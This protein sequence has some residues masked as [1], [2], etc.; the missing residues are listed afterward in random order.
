MA[1][2]AWDR[3]PDASPSA[4]P[5]DAFPDA[6]ASPRPSSLPGDVAKSAAAGV[7]DGVLSFGGSIG[8]VNTLAGRGLAWGLEKLAGADPSPQQREAIDAVRGGPLALLHPK[9]T[10]DLKRP[11]EA[12]TGPFHKP[13]TT[14]GEYARTIGEFA[15]SA[16]LGS[17]RLGARIVGDVLIPAVAS[18]TAGQV[19]EGTAAEPFA[20]AAGALGGNLAVAGARAV[21]GAPTSV[22]ARAARAVDPGQF[23]EAQRLAETARRV[24]VP[25][26][27]PEAIGEATRGGSKLA[28]VQRTV[29]GSLAGGTTTSRFFSQ[30][31]QQVDAA[32]RQV[33]DAI[34]PAP[35]AP[36]TL[37]PRAAQAAEVALDDVRRGINTATRPAYAAAEAHALDP[38]DFEPIARDPAFAASLRRLRADEVLGPQF[39]GQPDNSIAVID[40]V[41]KDMRDRGVALANSA[42]PG[43][44]GL[45]SAAYSSGAT[46]AR[47][48]ARAPA[49]GGVQA[50][51][52]ALTMQS[53]ARRQN[54]EPLEQG[55]LGRIA[56]AADTPAAYGEILPTKPLAG[57]V[58]EI[59][60]A[61]R[62][63]RGQ[64]AEL[65]PS[66]VR[67]SLADGFDQASR[68]I[69]TGD[70]QSVGGRFA[71]A[72][73][74]TP[75]QRATLDAVLEALGLPEA[76]QQTNDL[77]DVLRAT[78]QRRP[79]GSPTDANRQINERLDQVAMPVAIAASP[80]SA[81]S[82]V[83]SEIR[84]RVRQAAQDRAHSELAELFTAPDSVQLI[85]ELAARRDASPLAAMFA[86][87][88]LQTQAGRE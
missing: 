62:R 39:E 20:R 55:P 67:Q 11:V 7:A 88:A 43:F 74:G 26:S 50:Y 68:R 78:S 77:L 15:P 69:A 18:E 48:I 66:L 13:E 14:A 52:D 17:G 58:D 33:L 85:R 10:A 70:N 79:M 22:A 9:T 53:Q 1:A 86:R 16:A 80:A 82:S 28:D 41:T 59:T 31:P 32:T 25:L 2:D 23:D 12:V 8:D 5:F 24:G 83:F 84:D 57:G 29:E 30:R 35:A 37:G 49:R 56:T 71:N 34:A 72:V 19:T 4:D 60:D 81:G 47:D 36:S 51:D 3:F 27:G 44:S 73:A 46:E 45:K 65:P 21:A 40:A 64:D 63:L 54:L 42:N 76:R 38:A 61:V 87:Q 75:E 6:G